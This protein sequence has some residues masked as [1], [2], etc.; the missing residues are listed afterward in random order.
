MNI[1]LKEAMDKYDF[2]IRKYQSEGKKKYRTLEVRRAELSLCT[3]SNH[4]IEIL[5]QY[6]KFEHYAAI[7]DITVFEGYCNTQKGK[8]FALYA[9]Y[10]LRCND[11]GRYEEYL[12]KAEDY[13]LQAKQIYENWGNNYGVF[14]A[15]LLSILVH[16]MQYKKRTELVCI[17]PDTYRNRYSTLLLKLTE[18]YNSKQQ[19]LREYDI[20][21]YLQHNIS[22]MDIPLRILKFYPIIL[23]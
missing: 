6:E 17:N 5:N 23:Q 2:C 1:L 16:M 13:L 20:I 12:K 14:R 19:F 3:D 15:E 22:R 18:K 4:Y 9:D 8:A 7:N 21:E 11:I 10:M